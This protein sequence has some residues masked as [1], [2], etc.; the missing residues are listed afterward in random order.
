MVHPATD[1]SPQTYARIGGVLYLLIIVL[2]LF[3]EMVVR[4]SLVVTGDAAATASRI[5]ASP[6]LWRM[7]IVGDLLMHICDVPL[8]LIFYVLLRP[9]N[10][11][12]ALMAVLF[13]LVVTAVLIATK[14]NLFSAVFLL[15]NA[16]YLKVFEPGQLHALTYL[17][18]K[19]DS[20]GFGLG[21]IY[22][23]CECLVLGYLISKSGYLPRV[24][25]VL[26]QVAGLCYLINSFSLFLAPHFANLIFPLILIPAFVGESS[27]CLWL[28]IKGVNLEMWKKRAGVQFIETAATAV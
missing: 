21:L 1:T 3:G 17:F 23:G 19:L 28:L 7:G 16:E 6:L 22:F 9:V 15:G 26:M 12:L 24:L 10:R 13:N 5:M 8:M 11:N 25:G 27:L 18:I 2:G 4:D 20:Y 14:L